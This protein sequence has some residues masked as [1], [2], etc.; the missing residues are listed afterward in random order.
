[1]HKQLTLHGS[2]VC[3][4]YEMEGLLEHLARKGIHPEATVT[5]TFPLSETKQ[6]YEAFDAGKTG[7]VVISWD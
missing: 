1:L 5:H 2:W 3:G 4:I 6:A 7:K